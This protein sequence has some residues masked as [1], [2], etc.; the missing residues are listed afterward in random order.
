MSS[1][2]AWLLPPKPP[3]PLHPTQM[4]LQDRM[5]ELWRS[6]P[7]AVG[8]LG[9]WAVD[10][11]GGRGAEAKREDGTGGYAP[12]LWMGWGT[13]G[14]PEGRKVEG[15]HRGMF[16]QPQS[17]GHCSAGL[18]R[19]RVGLGRA[20]ATAGTLTGKSTWLS[21]ALHLAARAEPDLRAQ[22]PARLLKPGTAFPQAQLV[23]SALQ[24]VSPQ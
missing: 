2:W 14:R 22:S 15:P 21:D 17:R 7:A 19:L 6:G 5:M 13:G 10:K 20:W 11:G 9:I 12:L 4:H 16:H 1:T 23:L 8:R 3:K 24:G 18:T